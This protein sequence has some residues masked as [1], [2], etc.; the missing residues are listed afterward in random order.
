MW[1]ALALKAFFLH[2]KTQV[3]IKWWIHFYCHKPLK[4]TFSLSEFG[5]TVRLHI[6][7]PLMCAVS[8]Q[9]VRGQKSQGHKQL[10]KVFSGEFSSRSYTWSFASHIHVEI[11]EPEQ[12]SGVWNSPSCVRLQIALW[13]HKSNYSKHKGILRQTC[14]RDILLSV[15]WTQNVLHARL[16][17]I[18]QEREEPH[19]NKVKPL[20]E[21]E[22][23][24]LQTWLSCVR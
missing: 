12:N 9:E 22:R 11:I 3:G 2:T 14:A 5:G 4:L 8:H 15:W 1:N 16:A 17:L 18:T 6:C 7:I 13:T 19:R 10:K 21:Q 24:H 23:C 20:C